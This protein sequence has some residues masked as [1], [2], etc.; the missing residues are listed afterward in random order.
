MPSNDVFFVD[1]LFHATHFCNFFYVFIISTFYT[2]ALIEKG[3]FRPF[4]KA[5]SKKCIFLSTLS[6]LLLC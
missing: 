1:Y 2:N 6:F 5:Q 4:E 3:F